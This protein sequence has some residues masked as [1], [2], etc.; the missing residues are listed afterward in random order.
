MTGKN[1]WRFQGIALVLSLLFGSVCWAQSIG[2]EH[3]PAGNERLVLHASQSL[4]NQTINFV[5]VSS[6]KIV[7]TVAED[8]DNEKEVEFGDVDRDGD[9]DVVIVSAR[10][11]FFAGARRNKLYLNQGG[12]F[13][14]VTQNKI[15]GFMSVDVSR[16]GFLRDYDNDGWLDL[17]VVNDAYAGPTVGTTRYYANKH[18]N[19]TFS[20]FAD[21][22]N[23]LNGAVGDACGGFSADFNND[24]EMDLYLGNYPS[25]P[26]DTI[27]F[28]NG[29]GSFTEYT[30][31]FLPNDSD[32]TVDVAAADMNGDGKIDILLGN[33]G[34]P[35]F[36]YYNDNLGAGT[37]VGD[38]SYPQS[39]VSY[40]AQTGLYPALE[41]VDFNGDGKMD[42]YFA[43]KGPGTSD[44]LMI[45]MGNDATNRAVFTEVT[46]PG[47][48]SASPT[49]KVTVADLNNDNRPDLIVM[50][51]DTHNQFTPARRPVI[52]RNTSVNGETSFVEWTPALAFPTGLTH[53]GWHA[54]AFD[55]NN[56]RRLDIFIGAM[57]NDYLMV[58]ERTPVSHDSRVNGV[59][60]AFH[61]QSPQA[62]VGRLR[63][64]DSRQ[65][66][67]NGIPSGATVS[68]VLRSN[69]DTELTVYDNSGAVVVTSDRGAMGVEEALMFTAP[70]GQLSIKI[71]TKNTNRK[72]SQY[73]LELL[74]RTD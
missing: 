2:T 41:P 17:I 50:G 53:A 42:F 54:A 49:A 21:E 33:D 29:Q 68:A 19:G 66:A 32:Y 15:P 23:R 46:V 31:S 60:P 30:S 16:N 34:D 73:F 70:G 43:N 18:P 28:N 37:A 10:S 56:D 11:F 58:G 20:H 24:G 40:T 44:V 27:Y 22:T 26:Q 45:N 64:G 38:Y 36:I 52:F 55:T 7:Q 71:T 65:F 5:N 63:S 9:L 69:A 39:R 51:G 8:A 47:I 12:V 72:V 74:S 48:V 25:D 57:Q 14:E 67:A 61:N 13:N 35:A 59:V 3:G 6:T 4:S 62:I 1:L